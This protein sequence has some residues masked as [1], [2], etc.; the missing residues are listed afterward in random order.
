M[1]TFSPR[2]SALQS[3]VAVDSKY[4]KATSAAY[5]YHRASD[6]PK[7]G[8]AM[9][10]AAS[11][12]DSTGAFPYRAELPKDRGEGDQLQRPPQPAVI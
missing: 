5:T 8:K 2:E 3:R 1:Y 12:V 11:A 4:L 9:T 10:L 6:K 7:Q